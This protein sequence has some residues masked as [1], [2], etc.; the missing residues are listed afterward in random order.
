MPHQWQPNGGVRNEC[1]GATLASTNGTTVT[2]GG[3]GFQ[4][5]NWVTLGTTAF[6][7]EYFVLEYFANSSNQHYAV[8][9]AYWDG[10]AQ[11]V[12]LADDV[13][14]GV[15]GRFASEGQQ[16]GEF[17]VHIPAGVEL[18][19]RSASTGAGATIQAMIQG[20]S[21]GLRGMPGFSRCHY[22][23]QVS[24]DPGASI[25]TKTRQQLIAST[26]YAYKALGLRGDPVDTSR[27][28][29]ARGIFDIEMGA[30]SSEVVIVPN[31]AL[32]W[33]ANVDMPQDGRL[34]LYPV[35]IPAGTRMS[36]NSQC[37]INTA[38]DRTWGVTAYGF[39]E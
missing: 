7:Y 24:I 26:A 31:I 27:A 28:A 15:A 18:R 22:I 30:S 39:V 10:S 9:L 29:A 36:V 25:N 23:G 35:D 4:K 8:D 6:A 1:L 11:T 12:V 14:N 13:F 33:G 17:P 38:G 37:S 34:A 16:H 19:M 2:A 20:F 32:A 5:G 3:A 21:K